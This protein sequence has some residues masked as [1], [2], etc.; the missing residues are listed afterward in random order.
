MGLIGNAISQVFFQRASEAKAKGSL[1]GLVENAFSILVK[2]SLYP[3][4]LI[5]IIGRDLFTVVFGSVWA[6]AGV[7]A[8]ILGIY[9]FFW[10]ISTPL[11]NITNVLEKQQFG[12]IW[13]IGLFL[14]RLFSLG[15][16]GY[17]RNVY[18]SLG[19]FSVTGI[20]LYIT[21]F[22]IQFGWLLV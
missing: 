18:L 5:T 7:Y 14:S 16:G 3:S 1:K 19:L 21:L 6:E 10:F 22:V 13:N 20:I 8:Q 15:I 11:S 2:F 17:F 9:S 4:L 12:T